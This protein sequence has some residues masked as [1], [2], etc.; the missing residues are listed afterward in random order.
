MPHG[1]IV[2]RIISDISRQRP[3]TFEGSSEPAD[4][5]HW[6]EHFE[7]LFEMVDCPEEN[8]I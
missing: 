1:G 5:V 6:I 3:P 4:I 2:S 7:K 8:R